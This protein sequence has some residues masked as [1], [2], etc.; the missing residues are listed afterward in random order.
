MRPFVAIL[1]APL[2]YR[3]GLLHNVLP[4]ML[5]ALVAQTDTQRNDVDLGAR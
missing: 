2:I 1:C 3:Q 5:Q 4:P